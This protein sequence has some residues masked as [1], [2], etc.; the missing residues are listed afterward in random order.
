VNWWWIVLI[1]LGCLWA[2][3]MLGAHEAN[4]PRLFFVAVA[5]L[6]VVVFLFAQRLYDSGTNIL[7]KLG[8]DRLA[9]F[10]DRLKP[11][12]LPS[13]RIALLIMAAVSILFALL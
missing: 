3:P 5:F 4:M 10:R 11:K 8:R 7:R 12:V 9:D 13:A 1:P 2:L 6:W